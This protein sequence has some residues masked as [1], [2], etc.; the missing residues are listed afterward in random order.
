MLRSPPTT[1]LAGLALVFVTGAVGIYLAAR[2]GGAPTAIPAAVALACAT[3]LMARRGTAAGDARAV[4]W[5]FDQLLL[6]L[7]AALIIWLSFD[8]G[9]YFP[10]GPAVAGLLLIVVFVLRLTLVDEPLSGASR[11]LAIATGALALLA[12]WTLVSGV[13][14]DAPSRALVD[15]DRT[16]AYLLLLVLL[17]SSARTSMRLRWLAA[18]VAFGAVVIA[19]VAL[20]TR[21]LPDHFPTSIPAIGES[22]LAYPLTYS[23]ALGI[24]CVLGG[25]PCLYFATSTRLP[26]AARAV[27]AAALPLLATTV[28]LTLS[29]G[30]VA[31]AIAG[32]VA[33]VLLGRPR[34]L[35]P[36]AV[37][38]VPMSV[39]AVASAYQHPLLTSRDPTTAAAAAQGHT[40]AIVVVACV[41][42]AALLRFVLSPLDK[43]IAAYSLP[44]RTRRPVLAGAWAGVAVI[45]LAVAL[46]TH[47]PSRISD[48]YNRFVDS[49]QASPQQHDI[50]QSLFSSANRGLV[51]NWSVA[52]DAF[53]AAP[54]HGQGA[55]T[56]ENWW[57]EH[58]PARQRVYN[59]TDA[60]SLYVEV[61]GELGIVGFLLL[62]ALVGSILVAL[63]PIRRGPNRPL[64]AA[65]FAT[66]LAWAVHAGVDWDWE[67]PAVT[68]IFFAL[69]GAALAS[70]ASTAR[71]I[72]FSQG[73]R[74]TAGLLLLVSAITPGLVFASQ[75]QLNDARDALRA[76]DCPRAIERASDAV[77]TLQIRAEPYEVLAF[78]QQAR[79]RV[80]FAV[81]AMRKAVSHDPDNWR[82]HYELGVL[83][84]G[85]GLEAR[86]EIAKAHDLNPYAPGLAET[87]KTVPK[88]EAVNWDLELQGPSGAIL[89]A[90]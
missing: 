15:F 47:A 40:V 36:A 10:T 42:G 27:G 56:Y 45:V 62:L 43:R 51:D 31:A 28:Y 69:G 19:S 38:V 74:V 9:G 32:V 63:A 75:R 25:I 68:V 81:A 44:D 71:R 88:G 13:W 54:L 76:G 26:P 2:L 70:H 41:V 73:A 18:S 53:R 52:V 87:L 7:P 84:G 82:Y 89:N 34:G 37:A 58:R 8:A 66:A 46:V 12:L 72:P 11:P 22:N 77:N 4:D 16:F 48:Q 29:R 86:P 85:A 61:L 5:V 35:L 21:L 65:L 80:G 20:A 79:G 17:G 1:R 59:V 90:P 24:L 49:G 30:P 3:A 67:M 78:C 50:R 6:A 64:Y 23:N 55:G 60:H 83:L 33:F 57:N 14:S 39:I